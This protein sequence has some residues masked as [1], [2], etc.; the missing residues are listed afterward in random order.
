MPDVHCLILSL[1]VTLDDQE[2][3]AAESYT[4]HD[5]AQTD[6]QTDKCTDRYTDRQTGARTGRRT[7][8]QT[9]VWTDRQT[10]ALTGRRT[11]RRTDREVDGFALPDDAH[12]HVHG[13]RH[14]EGLHVRHQGDVPRGL[15]EVN[16]PDDSN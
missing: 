15:G 12:S 13:F 7:D 11:D 2:I 6:R 14:V 9:G 1:T 8:R 16:R 4:A 10:S 3:H 5:D